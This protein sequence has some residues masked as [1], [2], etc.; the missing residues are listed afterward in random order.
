MV[1]KAVPSPRQGH[2]NPTQL[3]IPSLHNVRQIFAV[4]ALPYRQK[5]A[6]QHHKTLFSIHFLMQHCSKWSLKRTRDGRLLR[7]QSSEPGRHLLCLLLKVNLV[8][9]W[10]R[11]T[12][13]ARVAVNTVQ[14]QCVRPQSFTECE[15]QAIGSHT[16]NYRRS[17]IISFSLVLQR[18]LWDCR[19]L[20]M[21]R[22]LRQQTK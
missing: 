9:E 10:D 6:P 18:T 12:I 22:R 15:N 5:E 11:D 14:S 16:F 7:S 8:F 20:S 2:I 1:S 3:I 19:L 13:L 21:D 17:I 4:A